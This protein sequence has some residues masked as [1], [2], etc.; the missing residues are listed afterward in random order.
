MLLKPL[1]WRPT[2]LEDWIY[3]VIMWGYS[4]N[5]YNIIWE[6]KSS[7]LLP[8]QVFPCGSIPYVIVI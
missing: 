4:Y 1:V 5:I 8:A 6:F 2:S 7:G 3:K